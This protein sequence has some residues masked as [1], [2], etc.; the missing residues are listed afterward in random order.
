M[1]GSV[2]LEAGTPLPDDFVGPARPAETITLQEPTVDTAIG[3]ARDTL[4]ALMATGFDAACFVAPP[5]ENLR[6][7][8]PHG[9]R[10]NIALFSRHIALFAECAVSAPRA[11]SGRRVNTNGGSISG[12]KMGG[13]G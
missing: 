9:P 6:P 3:L 5:D 11:L 12:L 10:R 2:I 13:S 1:L 7:S 8:V 4:D